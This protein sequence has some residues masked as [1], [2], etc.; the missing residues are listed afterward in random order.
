MKVGRAVCSCLGAGE[1]WVRKHCMFPVYLSPHK[2][3][4]HMWYRLWILRYQKSLI[5]N[6]IFS[7]CSKESGTLETVGAWLPLSTDCANVSII[8]SPWQHDWSKRLID[9]K[10]VCKERDASYKCSSSWRMGEILCIKFCGSAEC[11][12]HSTHNYH[13]CRI[14]SNR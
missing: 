10:E 4:P 8:R 3:S 1:A 6:N 14:S 7:M 2:D 5:R 13:D 11:F 12:S 9:F